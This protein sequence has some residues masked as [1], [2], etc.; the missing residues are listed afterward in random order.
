MPDSNALRSGKR[1]GGGRFLLTRR[2]AQGRRGEVWLALDEQLQE[3]VALKFLPAEIRAHVSALEHLQR[4][5]ARSRRL[6]HP[7]IVRL[8]DLHQPLEEPPFIAMEYVD[9]ASLKN[10]PPQVTDEVYSFGATIYYLVTG[11]A[12]FE[13]KGETAR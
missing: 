5:M 4:E 2:M 10:K 1:V 8:Y 9:G 12:P 7:H 13:G 3:R 6:A 11:Q